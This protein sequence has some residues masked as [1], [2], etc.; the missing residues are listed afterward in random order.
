[1]AHLLW[2]IPWREVLLPGPSWAEKIIRPVLIYVTL[3]IIFRLASKREL[4]QATLFDFLIILLISN[5]VQNA[6]IG[7]D[8]SV[9]GAVVGAIVLVLLSGAL[10]R[11]TARSKRSRV[12]LE[13]KP[14]LL[15]L[16]GELDEKAMLRQSI[17]RNDLFMAVRKQG[18]S[19]LAD[20]GFAILELDGS[21][22]V[23]PCDDDTR[24]RDC[25]PP[26]AVGAESREDGGD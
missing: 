21:I 12:F 6:M 5:V 1:M 13:G 16:Q 26:E 25:L 10:N 7:N 15:I 19:R 11:L 23:I 2:Y 22:S 9:L 3:L 18:L 4:A 14:T 20:V 8:S 24:P 17:S